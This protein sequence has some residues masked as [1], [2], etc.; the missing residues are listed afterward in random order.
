MISTQPIE[1]LP[2]TSATGGAVIA[3]PDAQ[4]N[5]NGGDQGF[6]GDQGNSAEANQDAISATLDEADLYQNAFELLR[7]SKHS[8]AV[9]VF[10]EQIKEFPYGDYADDAN[11][12]IA[13]SKYV[14]RDLSGSKKFFKVILDDYK[15][16]PR[17]PDAMLK[18]AYIEQEQ[19]NMIEARLL[20]QEVLQYHPRSNAAI[21][22][23][24]RLAE[25]DS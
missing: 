7:Q 25:L 9:K 5:V 2:A 19:G 12:W 13:E 22:A 17:L 6:N 24:N 3:V 11:Y 16:S 21:S 14:N 8:E 4:N 20:L 15:Q 18:I 10:T 1:Q 23:R